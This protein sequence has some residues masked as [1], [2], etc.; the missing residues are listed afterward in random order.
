MFE[1]E[2]LTNSALISSGCSC[3]PDYG[4]DCRPEG[5]CGPEDGSDDCNPYY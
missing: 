2:C 1:L 5:E 3:Y 4:L